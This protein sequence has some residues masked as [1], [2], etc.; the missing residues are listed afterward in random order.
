VLIDYCQLATFT[1]DIRHSHDCL[2]RTSSRLRS[3][4]VLPPPIRCYFN[5]PS[6]ALAR[7]SDALLH[8]SRL[9][10]TGPGIN[11]T[12]TTLLFTS[13][14]LHAR[15][16]P[17][18]LRTSLQS[19][20]QITAEVLLFLRLSGL[21]H[22]YRHAHETWT[23]P[24]RDPA[25]KALLWVE[26]ALAAC[27]QA[28]ENVAFLAL[29]G[30][31]PGPQEAAKWMAVSNRVWMARMLLSFLRMLRV[32]QLRWREELGAE[33]RAD[34]EGRVRTR[35]EELRRKWMRQVWT[36]TGWVPVMM[37]WTY[38]N[39]PGSPV[40]ETWQAGVGLMG[41]WLGLKDAWRQ[42]A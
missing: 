21:F 28:L 22:I 3:A 30:I 7:S 16:A 41:S 8:A 32:R 33:S 18:R 25:I 31:L 17:S 37:H 39:E 12:L 5:M 15:L 14:F 4:G 35:S 2:A 29:K 10:S 13:A 34:G 40:G 42:T 26:L 9:L 38:M 27:F 6:S 24:H 1:A 19:L 23:T 20:A 11:S 36:S